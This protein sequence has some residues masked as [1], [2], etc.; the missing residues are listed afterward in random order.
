M[1]G[2]AALAALALA[3]AAGGDTPLELPP[4]VE[5]RP[6]QRRPWSPG[7]DISALLEARDAQPVVLSGTPAD[8][9]AISGWSPA[10]IGARLGGRLP[11]VRTSQR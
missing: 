11:G 8:G 5:L 3:A 7:D 6:V 4:N 10:T 9:W 1:P 2:R